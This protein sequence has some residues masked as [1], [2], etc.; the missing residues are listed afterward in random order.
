[1][2]APT[3]E[4]GNITLSDTTTSSTTHNMTPILD[5]D[6]AV[7]SGNDL[8]TD[9]EV[10][11]CSLALSAHRP[12]TPSMSS[13]ECDEE[14]HVRVKRRSDRMD[15][16]EPVASVGS[17]QVEYASQ[18]GRNG[19]VS[20]AADNTNNTSYQRVTNED[21]ASSSPSGNNMF[22]VQLNYDIDQALDPES[23]D[24]KFHAISLHGSMEH[25]VSDVKNIKDS[26]LRIGKYIKG[27][28]IIDGNA[29]SVKDLE[30]VGKVVWEF[31]SAVY[32]SH[33]DSLH[34]DNFKMLF[35]NKVKSKFTTQVPKAP[36]NN[37][38]KEVVTPTYI[39][40]ISPFILAK[41]FKEVNE[42]SKFFKKSNNLQKKSY[43]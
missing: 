40:P 37:K 24:G 6:M 7:D 18:E 16:D 33:W 30:G 14:Y 23:W 22:N 34:V 13:S 4:L 38:D 31:L 9:E 43:I 20:E 11:G 10:R 15:E 29:N 42:I 36:T 41:T 3:R 35:R 21:L 1:M 39:S 12:R 32:D 25:L 19:Q 17:I 26:L 27:K 2:V 5:F 28:S 8:F